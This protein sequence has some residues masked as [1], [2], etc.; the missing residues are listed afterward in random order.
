MINLRM[1]RLLTDSGF[2]VMPIRWFFL[3]RESACR[4]LL[5]GNRSQ[6]KQYFPFRMIHERIVQ[7]LLHYLSG[8]QHPSHLFL[9]LRKA[10]QIAQVMPHRAM[11]FAFYEVSLWIVYCAGKNSLNFS[12]FFQTCSSSVFDKIY[13]PLASRVVPTTSQSSSP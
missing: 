2:S 10:I 7:F 1:Q 3:Y 5:Q 13:S 9:S 11:S 6:S 12:S 4:S 8:D